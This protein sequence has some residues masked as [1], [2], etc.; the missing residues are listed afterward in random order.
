[1]SIA[2][3]MVMAGAL[4]LAISVAQQSEAQ[5]G[6]RRPYPGAP[7]GPGADRR[8]YPGGPDGPGG[9]QGPGKQ[10]PGK[11][12]GRPGHAGPP[13][14]SAA[15][16]AH[17]RRVAELKQKEADGTLTDEEKAELE[18]LKQ[19]RQGKAARRAQRRAR[20]A[21]LKQK[22]ADGK[23][24]DEE[25]KELEKIQQ[26]QQRHQELMR[27]RGAKAKS[28]IVR[29]RAAKRK[30][31]KECPRLRNKDQAALAEYGKHGQRMAKLERAREV[32]QAE[33]RNELVARI[34]KLI[35]KE[36]ERH[37][38]WVAKHAGGEK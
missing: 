22:Q 30:A 12:K 29:R 15:P 3:L 11:H 17:G 32:A 8:P 13:V 9:K 4:G 35:A 6:K 19:R 27:K 26:V 24:T 36:K 33:G 7:G 18:Q 5:G 20:L 2:R 16:G 1:M 21:E 34:D 28:R 23:L 25:K 37:Q 38:S 10:G 14:G 31:L